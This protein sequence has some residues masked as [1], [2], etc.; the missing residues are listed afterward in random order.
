MTYYVY[1]RRPAPGE[2][3]SLWAEVEL[4]SQA[5]AEVE[6]I[7]AEGLLA[8]VTTRELAGAVR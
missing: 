6:L 1:C 8:L 7:R 5:D 2:H 4:R 3:W